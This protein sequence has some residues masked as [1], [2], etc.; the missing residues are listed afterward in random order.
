MV[1]A[2]HEFRKLIVPFK[3]SL[4]RRLHEYNALTLVKRS[5]KLISEGP[6]LL[7]K[8]Y[9]AARVNVTH[10]LISNLLLSIKTWMAYLTG[11]PYASGSAIKRKGAEKWLIRLIQSSNQTQVAVNTFKKWFSVRLIDVGKRVEK[12]S[13]EERRRVQSSSAWPVRNNKRLVCLPYSPSL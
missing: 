5:W 11:F 3:M 4:F 10:I 9:Y 12:L 7:L 8:L 13:L 1:T 2:L 6:F